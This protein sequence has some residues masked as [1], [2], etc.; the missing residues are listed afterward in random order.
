MRSGKF[1][2]LVC[3]GLSVLMLYGC[4]MW[5]DHNE[6]LAKDESFYDTGSSV[7][8]VDFSDAQKITLYV[9]KEVDNKL[10]FV[11]VAN[12]DVLAP[13]KHKFAVDVT[14]RIING[15]V[16][17]ERVFIGD[18]SN[19]Y[20]VEALPDADSGYYV[21]EYQLAPV[22]YFLTCPILI[23]VIYD[24][25]T[26]SKE[27]FVVRTRGGMG[28]PTGYL[29]NKGL[30]ISLS[31]DMLKQAIKVANPLIAEQI[32]GVSIKDMY[33]ATGGEKGIITVDLGSI[34][35]DIAL[36]DTKKGVRGLN[37]G[38]E[39]ITGGSGSGSIL[40]TVV[41]AILKGILGKGFDISGISVGALGFNITD[42]ISGLSAPADP[43]SDDPLAGILSGLK[44]D[45]VMFLNLKGLP[46]ST[47]EE[48]AIIGGSIY[49]APAKDVTKDEDD[50]YVWPQVIEDST[51]T[52]MDMTMLQGDIA[53][54]GIAL[55]DYNLNQ[56]FSALMS[57]FSIEI[58]DIQKLTDFFA[59][60][61]PN[62]SMNLIASINPGGI[63]VDMIN[64]RVAVNDVRLTLVEAGRPRTELSL[65]VTLKFE[66]GFHSDKKASY[67]D[68]TIAPQY[69][70]CH[71]H[72]MKD[73]MEMDMF[74]H[75]TYFPLIIEG[76]A[77]G[78]DEIKVSLPLTDFGIMPKAGIDPGEVEYDNSGNCYMKM[79]VG[80]LDAS[81]LPVDGLC[82]I[83]TAVN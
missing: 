34:S 16:A 76:F 78:F 4:G 15:K 43:N 23:Q 81:K 30:G 51:D 46:L 40:N 64:Q 53:D 54:I 65:D 3:V 24:D 18:G 2:F 60:E 8:A 42:M 13:G 9:S 56:V 25:A 37:I 39:N 69:D 59:P 67:L 75:S 11:K 21:C 82:F 58:K 66:A 62:N 26:A 73:N 27:K 17:P 41:S 71:I 49:A 77:N 36:E 57:G 31:K 80:D 29:V 35:C 22:D 50:N 12:G 7:K 47:T 61:D 28:S 52:G 72:V 44:L 20:Q 1:L 48:H 74:D 10:K 6:E 14:Q 68:L 45:S 5:S 33:P 38:L 70:R 55:S 79:A 63:A 19:D 32:K 83:S